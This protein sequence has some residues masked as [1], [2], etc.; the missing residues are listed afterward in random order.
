MNTLRVVLKSIISLTLCLS[1]SACFLSFDRVSGPRM[2]RVN[3]IDFMKTG[4][5]LYEVSKSG[6]LDDDPSFFFRS[7]PNNTTQIWAWDKD[8]NEWK[9]LT[10]MTYFATPSENYFIGRFPYGQAFAYFAFTFTA[11]NKYVQ[12]FAANELEPVKGLTWSS[13]VNLFDDIT[14]GRSHSYKGK[15]YKPETSKFLIKLSEPRE[16]RASSSSSGCAEYYHARSDLERQQQKLLID[17]PGTAATLA[18]CSAG[19]ANERE[20]EA[21]ALVACGFACL[22]IGFENCVNFFSE[23]MAIERYERRVESMNHGCSA[24]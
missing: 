21:C 12:Y 11:N 3:S 10:E 19:C 24:R 7:K 4:G 14:N 2:V 13:L 18:V 17:Y 20:P 9:E 15:V 8:K 1:L 16:Q 23:A 5:S 6:S 22:G